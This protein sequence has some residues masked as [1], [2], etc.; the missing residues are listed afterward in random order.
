[1]LQQLVGC[2]KMARHLQTFSLPNNDLFYCSRTKRRA[3][4]PL[5]SP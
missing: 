3:K 2:V 5:G 4:I 1:M